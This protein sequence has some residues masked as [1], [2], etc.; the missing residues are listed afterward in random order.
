MPKSNKDKPSS[1]DQN[2]EKAKKIATDKDNTDSKLGNAKNMLTNLLKDPQNNIES[3]NEL[4]ADGIFVKSLSQNQLRELIQNMEPGLFN[5]EAFANLVKHPSLKD[6]GIEYRTRL[7]MHG[8]YECGTTEACSITK[9]ADYAPKILEE[10]ELND[11]SRKLLIDLTKKLITLHTKKDET[12]ILVKA[13]ESLLAKVDNSKNKTGILQEICNISNLAARSHYDSILDLC[14]K[15]SSQHDKKEALVNLISAYY[16]NKQGELDKRLGKLLEV[17]KAEEWLEQPHIDA[18]AKCNLTK[19]AFSGIMKFQ[20]NSQ[21]DFTGIVGQGIKRG[22]VDSTMLVDQIDILNNKKTILNGKK[23]RKNLSNEYQH[24]LQSAYSSQEPN[25]NLIRQLL[26][27]FP[28]DLHTNKRNEMVENLKSFVGNEPKTLEQKQAAAL[29]FE[30]ND[31]KYACRLLF[32]A[33][34]AATIEKENILVKKDN[35]KLSAIV[36]S[37]KQ[38]FEKTTYKEFKKAVAGDA[39]LTQLL[40]EKE[41]LHGIAVLE[42]S[43]K[44]ARNANLH[45]LSAETNCLKNFVEYVVE[46]ITKLFNNIKD[47]YVEDLKHTI[48]DD[49]KVDKAELRKSIKSELRT[50]K[51]TYQVDNAAKGSDGPVR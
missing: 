2:E 23:V 30:I 28:N 5:K 3:I 13:I 24:L 22:H 34:A 12:P 15:N 44:S 25:P 8:F 17:A 6:L 43:Y 37:L 31:P 26:S 7:L 20:E 14:I 50:I 45:E 16:V 10:T 36:N 1:N 11:A 49:V 38:G 39:P 35:T 47:L 41:H 29:I 40:N 42:S 32:S 46:M 48:I 4:L 27:N 19:N 21:L 9:F 51:P 33:L 18:L